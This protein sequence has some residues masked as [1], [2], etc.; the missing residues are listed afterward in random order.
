MANWIHERV[1]N[2]EFITWEV[3]QAFTREALEVDA[4]DES[5]EPGT[6]VLKAD[7]T[8]AGIVVNRVNKGR[9]AKTAAIVRGQA[10]VILDL[11]IFPKGVIENAETQTQANARVRAEALEDLAAK[12][13]IARN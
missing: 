5:V 10:I 8:V 6:V 4:T 13:I 9:V 12:G 11:L 7:G 1:Q 3:N 2:G